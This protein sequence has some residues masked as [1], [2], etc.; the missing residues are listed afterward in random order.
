[1]FRIF[2]ENASG[3]KEEK[4]FADSKTKTEVSSLVASLSEGKLNATSFEETILKKDSA[5]DATKKALIKEIDIS[6]TLGGAA[7]GMVIGGLSDGAF[8]NGDAPWAPLAGPVLVGGLAYYLT[9]EQRDTQVGDAANALL[10]RPVISLRDAVVA[11]AQQVLR[12]L[13]L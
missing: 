2:A 8:F 4:G 1:M 11:R 6:T 5:L 3:G 13:F 9:T 10:G 7:L 12:I